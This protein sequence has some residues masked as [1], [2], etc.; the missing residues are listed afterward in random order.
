[1]CVC[2]WIKWQ[3]GRINLTRGSQVVPVDQDLDSAKEGILARANGAE[4]DRNERS[5]PERVLIK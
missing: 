2:V 4:L 5:N 3:K 1:M